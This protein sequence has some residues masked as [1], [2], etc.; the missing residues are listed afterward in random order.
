MLSSPQIIAQG[1]EMANLDN[2]N[3][4][5]ISHVL[6][7][8]EFLQLSSI[9]PTDAYVKQEERSHCGHSGDA[10]HA[11][12][13]EKGEEKPLGSSEESER[14]ANAGPPPPENGSSAQM[15]ALSESPSSPG[16]TKRLQ[17]YGSRGEKLKHNY[18]LNPKMWQNITYFRPGWVP[19]RLPYLHSDRYWELKANSTVVSTSV[20]PYNKDQK[21]DKVPCGVTCYIHAEGPWCEIQASNG[22]RICILVAEPQN[23]HH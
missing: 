19:E 1:R 23:E 16:P 22:T 11:Q 5:S 6:G 21:A 20:P 2:R 17:L 8:E 7:E 9:N 13:G 12:A 14:K 3:L 10:G 15:K 4:F 18:I